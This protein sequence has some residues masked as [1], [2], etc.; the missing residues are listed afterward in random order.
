MLPG[1]LGLWPHYDAVASSVV[2]GGVDEWL[3]GTLSEDQTTG[4][5]PWNA[6]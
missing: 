2:R 6:N 3:Q 5:W 4:L 1:H